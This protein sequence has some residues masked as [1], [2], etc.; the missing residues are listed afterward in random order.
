MSSLDLKMT[1]IFL[2]SSNLRTMENGVPT[3]RVLPFSEIV[4]DPD[5]VITSADGSIATNVQFKSLFIW[6]VEL[7]MQYV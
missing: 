2:L 7:N 3:P 6:K 5:D 1:W 4:L